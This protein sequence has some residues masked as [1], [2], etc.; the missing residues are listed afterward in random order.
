MKDPSTMYWLFTTAPQAIAALVGIIFTGMFFMAESIDNRAKD[1]QSLAEI[2]D[3]AK[4]TLYRNMQGV[5]LLAIITILYDLLLVSLVNN[6][7]RS[8][9]FWKDCALMAF[10]GLNVLTIMMTFIYVFKTVN[11]NYFNKIAASLSKEYKAAGDV[12]SEVF[13]NHFI[14]FERAARNADV[15]VQANAHYLGIRDILRIFV[16]NNI[17]T[18]DDEKKMLEISKIRNLIAHG[19][20]IEKVSRKYD[21]ELLRITEIIKNS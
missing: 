10:V 17:I 16:S 15:V 19:E 20:F 3:E 14:K 4:R 1:D 18:R 7:A 2:A 21:D 13:F 5:A 8:D 11:P 9:N 6:L 12:D